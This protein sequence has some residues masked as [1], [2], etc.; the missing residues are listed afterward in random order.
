MTSGVAGTASASVEE[1]LE[2]LQVG[3]ALAA[4]LPPGVLAADRRREAEFEQS[5][6]VAVGGLEHLTEHAVE[7]GGRDGVQGDPS[8]QVDVA[9]PVE[10]VVHAVEPGIALQ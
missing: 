5:V 6:E 3:E 9:D 2:G 4:L 1:V 7:L 8:D 10:R